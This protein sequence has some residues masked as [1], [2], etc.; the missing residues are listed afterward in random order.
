MSK[1]FRL[2]CLWR[3]IL[4]TP[5]GARMMN[6]LL[7]R[8]YKSLIPC[9]RPEGSQIIRLRNRLRGNTCITDRVSDLRLHFG[10]GIT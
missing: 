5:C 7:P 8:W 1:L 9:T 4:P 6:E 3:P 2:L 10:M